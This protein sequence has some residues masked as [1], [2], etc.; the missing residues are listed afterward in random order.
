VGEWINSRYQVDQG[1]FSGTIGTDQSEDLT[2]F[3]TKIDP[4][5]RGQ[6]AEQD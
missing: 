5:D 4:V 1:C 2:I 3:E 6:S